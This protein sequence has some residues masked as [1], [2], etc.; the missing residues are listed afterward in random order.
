M[1]Y[2]DRVPGRA[3]VKHFMSCNHAAATHTAAKWVETLHEAATA[4]K[5]QLVRTRP[6][7]VSPRGNVNLQRHAITS[8]SLR[9][10]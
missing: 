2:M 4:G 9:M 6:C 1:L 3:K 8:H 10:S 5:T 7:G